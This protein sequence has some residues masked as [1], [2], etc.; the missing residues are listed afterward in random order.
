MS[1]PAFNR[2]KCTSRPST[3]ATGFKPNQPTFNYLVH[4]VNPR[5]KSGLTNSACLLPKIAA[6]PWPSNAASSLAVYHWK[7]LRHP[8]M[9]LVVV[10]TPVAVV[11]LFWQSS[12]T[13]FRQPP[14][15]YLSNEI[16]QRQAFSVGHMQRQ[17][18]RSSITAAHL[19][20]T[21]VAFRCFPDFLFQRSF[22]I[23]PTC[24]TS[25]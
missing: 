5:P 4:R 24:S 22:V 21:L 25:Y 19:C 1:K 12:S 15:G 17:K 8:S 10:V 6:S 7:L 2:P 13:F 20:Q 18:P 16:L 11:T 3:R 9:L 23:P 14:L